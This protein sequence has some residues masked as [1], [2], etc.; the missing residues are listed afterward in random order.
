MVEAS[1]ALAAAFDGLEAHRRWHVLDLG[2][3]LQANIE[4][5]TGLR[6]VVHVADLARDLPAAGG[7]DPAAA[8]GPRL[9][10]AL[11]VEPPTRFDLVLAWDLVNYLPPPALAALAATLSERTRRDSLLLALVWNRPEM[12]GL[13]MRFRILDRGRLSYEGATRSL[14]PAPRYREHD[15]ERLLEGF[16]VERTFLLRSGLQEYLLRTA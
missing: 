5:L 7:P 3:A 4:F 8:V 16:R 11:R 1:A 13:P 2:A 10:E 9:L 12:P 15:L 6:A 14:L